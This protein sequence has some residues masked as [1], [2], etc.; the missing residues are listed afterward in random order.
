[1]VR[2]AKRRVPSWK[3]RKAPRRRMRKARISRPVGKGFLKV[4]RKHDLITL[5]SSATLGVAS[6]IDNGVGTGCLFT[7]TPQ[8]SLGTVAGYYD[9]PFSMRFCLN[10][11]RQ[12]SEFAQLFDSYKIQ[13]V[14]VK[15]INNYN[16]VMNPTA[17]TTG[18]L[19]Y[20]EYE[21]DHDDYSVPTVTA[22]RERMGIK[23]KYFNSTTNTLSM[24]VR[25]KYATDATA[26]SGA[27]AVL[28]RGGWLNMANTSIEHYGIKGV[29]R[30]VFLP[31]GSQVS[32]F[33]FD[34]TSHFI[35]KDIQ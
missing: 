35:C 29:I 5:V 1:M 11:V 9:V 6:V 7:G 17:S 25:P 4:A 33:T 14:H 10:Q 26:A 8:A 28:S 18:Y 34:I 24:G 30:R 15:V 23:T 16:V 13:S 22:W 27:G 12:S 20:I 31:A 32:N 3:K 19:P 2:Y 21:T